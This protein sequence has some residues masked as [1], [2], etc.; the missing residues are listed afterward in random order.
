MIQ[1]NANNILPFVPEDYLAG[2]AAALEQAQ[3]WLQD[4]TGAG[5][6][7]VGWVH[8]PRD[9][10]KAEFARI[11]TAAKKIQDQSSALVVIGIGGS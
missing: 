5:N 3:A 9:Y 11:K 7:F 2:R 4:A 6:D 1:V 8:L 10:D